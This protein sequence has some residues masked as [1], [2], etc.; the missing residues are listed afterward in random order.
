MVPH[1][2]ERGVCVFVCTRRSSL[3]GF[4]RLLSCA[5]TNESNWTNWALSRRSSLFHRLHAQAI[6]AANR[7]AAAA[8]SAASRAMRS[9]WAASAST[10]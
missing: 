5:R 8:F 9:S 2:P 7:A 10:M 3:Y 4:G 1:V 6:R